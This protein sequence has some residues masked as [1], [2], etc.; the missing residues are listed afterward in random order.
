[1]IL[2][3]FYQQGVPFTSPSSVSSDMSKPIFR[4]Q[5]CAGG[6]SRSS[7]RLHRHCSRLSV[8]GAFAEARA[9]VLGGLGRAPHS[10]VAIRKTGI[11]C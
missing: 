9:F 10:D 7:T 3:T 6:P 2:N 5:E 8:K 1:M 11:A 4:P